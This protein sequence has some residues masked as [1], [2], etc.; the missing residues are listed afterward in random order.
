MDTLNLKNKI[1]LL[2]ILVLVGCKEKH[3]C[4]EYI[5]SYNFTTLKI[6]NIN[7]QEIQNLNFFVK[8]N[9]NIINEGHLE[10]V[11]KLSQDRILVKFKFSKEDTIYKTDTIYVNFKNT[12]HYITGTKEV[13]VESTGTP[14]IKVY[15]VDGIEFIEGEVVLKNQ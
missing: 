10:F 1:I 7:E 9:D 13:C 6:E 2:L 4:N 8:R 15:N 3:A 12:S 14:F 5:L 11:D